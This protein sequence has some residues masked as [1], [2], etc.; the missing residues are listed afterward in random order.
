MNLFPLNIT[1]NV[2]EHPHI[3]EISQNTVI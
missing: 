3:K 2:H 1:Y